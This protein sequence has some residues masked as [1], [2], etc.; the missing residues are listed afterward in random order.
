MSHMLK[1]I[2][3]RLAR[4]APVA[5]ISSVKAYSVTR[6]ASQANQKDWMD[7][8]ESHDY[9][10]EAI[11]SINEDTV[12]TFGQRNTTLTRNMHQGCEP[13]TPTIVQKDWMSVSEDS[14]YTQEA[15]RSV[16][17]DTIHNP[18][19]LKIHSVRSS[20]L[21][22]PSEGP[23]RNTQPTKA[24]WLDAEDFQSTKEAIRAFKSDTV[25]SLSSSAV[26]TAAEKIA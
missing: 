9:V 7:A 2:A 4:P 21:E 22:V 3:S 16:L 20:C 24:D 17:Q 1:V 15:I 13:I 25:N 11:R 26:Y 23:T 19:G 10:Q 8:D 6:R 18:V 5:M 12:N 14:V